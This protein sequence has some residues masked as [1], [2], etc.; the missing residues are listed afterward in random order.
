MIFEKVETF[1]FR[2]CL[3]WQNTFWM[4]IDWCFTAL[5]IGSTKPNLIIIGSQ[6]IWE[7]TRSYYN[8]PLFDDKLWRKK[9]KETHYGPFTYNLGNYFFPET[10]RLSQTTSQLKNLH[11]HTPIQL[12]CFSTLRVENE[13]S[14]ISS[15]TEI[16]RTATHGIHFPNRR[17][18]RLA[19]RL[20]AARSTVAIWAAQS[21]HCCIA[22]CVIKEWQEVSLQTQRCTVVIRNR[23]VGVVRTKKLGKSWMGLLC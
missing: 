6:E 13:F 23:C 9:P 21:K 7:I 17:F 11:P 12:H 8:R 22:W 2:Y 4:H 3:I 15:C 16:W 18:P 5:Y 14:F 10:C 19:S 1:F 20:E